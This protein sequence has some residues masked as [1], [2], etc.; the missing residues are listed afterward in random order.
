MRDGGDGEHEE[1]RGSAAQ[2]KHGGR[3]Y[4]IARRAVAARGTVRA[5]V[6]GTAVVHADE[7]LKIVTAH[8]VL[9]V[10]WSDAPSLEQLR[11]MARAAEAL[12]RAH[13]R[14][15]ALL[16]VIRGGM[17][18]FDDA[19]RDEA[20]RLTRDGHFDVGVAH[21]VLIGGLV[22]AAVRAFLSTIVLLGRPKEPTQVFGE[23]GAA[24]RWL[25]G[26]LAGGGVSW[27]PNDLA[28]ALDHAMAG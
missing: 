10:V 26:R 25:A 6:M 17:P 7:S 18:S 2:Q 23:A 12:R 3:A 14:G 24:L 11:A 16:N 20:R 13:P 1:K 22:G 8:N 15:T 19:V 9:V 27:T 28:G 4:P 21:V 5:F